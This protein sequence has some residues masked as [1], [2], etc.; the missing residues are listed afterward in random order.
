MENLFP[1]PPRGITAP[2][3]WLTLNCDSRDLNL[4][5][6]KICTPGKEDQFYTITD[7]MGAKDFIFK[8]TGIPCTL[9]YR[10]TDPKYCDVKYQQ[11][12]FYCNISN[13][14]SL[15]LLLFHDL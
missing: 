10:K 3:G 8:F 7:F 15:H 4:H 14:R 12:E 9:F 6:I 5:Y 11:W 2:K 1:R 13:N